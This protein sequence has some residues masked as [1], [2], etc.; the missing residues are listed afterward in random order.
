[1]AE[2]EQVAT[3]ILGHA[4][5]HA[6][7]LDCSITGARGEER[8]ACDRPIGSTDLILNFVEE[9][10]SLSPKMKGITLG[11]TLGVDGGGLG[12]KAH[13]AY[14]S[15]RRAQDVARECAA[16]PGMILGLAAAHEIGHLLMSSGDHSRSG[17][18][19]ARWDAND[20]ER[21]ARGDLQFSDDQVMRINAGVLARITQENVPVVEA[22]VSR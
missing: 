3:Q 6:L 12:D 1:M 18:M 9:I 10:Q 15:N 4:G 7:W 22:A 13:F 2:A 5:V 17:I 20:L 14:I 19:R 11:L 8:P 21:A 16:S